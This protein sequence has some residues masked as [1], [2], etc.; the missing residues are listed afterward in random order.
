MI[1]YSG[2]AY[3]PYYPLNEQ[4]FRD[5]PYI[6]SI[7]PFDGGVE[8]ELVN[9]L[10]DGSNN[11]LLTSPGGELTEYLVT[12]NRIYIDGLKN[13]ETYQVV[14]IDKQ[15]PLRR[16]KP[17]LV[18]PGVAIGNVVNYLHPQDTCFEFSGNS[19]CSPGIVKLPSGSF[20][21]SMDIYR[22]RW[23]QNL[24]IIFR[25]DDGG[26][27]WYYVVDLFPCFWG[28]LFLHRGELYMLALT[29]EYGDVIIAK[30]K[31]NG[32][33]WTDFIRLFPGSGN[34]DCGG[35]HKAP[36]NIL[37]FGGRLWTSLDFGTWERD[38]HQSG[39]L[40]ISEDADLLDPKAW[41]YSKLLR[42]DPEWIG[43]AMGDSKGCLEGNMILM[44]NGT[45]CNLLRYQ[46]QLCTPS[47]DRAVL[48]R[49]D[50]NCPDNPCEFDQIIDF[51]G[52]LSKFSVLYDNVTRMYL[53]VVNIVKNPDRPMSRTALALT[54]S[55]DAVH[56]NIAMEI[57]DY[58]LADSNGDKIGVQYPDALIDGDDLVWVQRTAINGSLNFHDSNYI[59]FHRIRN[60]RQRL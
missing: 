1:G 54:C 4:S 23:G 10:T 57:M 38:G 45:L 30:S 15:N 25:S 18:K 29:T 59:T 48:L 43:A 31:D 51:P 9:C 7:R 17:R 46:I 56:W 26:K 5:C 19:L 60:F 49:V 28:K 21:V 14:I 39:V 40:S 6:A 2:F 33:S 34:R 41:V 37:P 13:N 44:P 12:E 53:A 52:G 20:L 42:Y 22:C 11:L 8:V 55:K 24:T 36:L 35:P 32:Q 16:S 3:S 27:S 47:H 50:L 58:S